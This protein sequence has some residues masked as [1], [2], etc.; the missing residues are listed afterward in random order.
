MNV[1]KTSRIEGELRITET[2]I[3]GGGEI[4]ILIAYAT[5]ENDN[6]WSFPT[7]QIFNETIYEKYKD[8]Y[9]EEVAK[10]R[11]N[12]NLDATTL[13]TLETDVQS[14]KER[15]ELVQAALDELLMGGDLSA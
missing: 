12:C 3:V 13:S 9:D 5:K 10:F 14:N 1:K 7:P 15:L 11:N 6:L 4:L 8:K 2:D